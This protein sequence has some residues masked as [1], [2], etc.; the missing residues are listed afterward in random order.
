M[1]WND[2]AGVTIVLAI[3]LLLVFWQPPPNK[4]LAVV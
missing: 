1:T 4:P 3:I 2:L